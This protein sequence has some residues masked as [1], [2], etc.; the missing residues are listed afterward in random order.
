MGSN[1]NTGQCASLHTLNLRRCSAVMDVAGLGQCVFLHT[2][3][4]RDCTAVT[5]VAGLG[6]YVTLHTHISSLGA[7]D[8]VIIIIGLGLGLGAH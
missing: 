4:L 2:F 8:Q 6:Q 7:M 5:D 1:R 3:D